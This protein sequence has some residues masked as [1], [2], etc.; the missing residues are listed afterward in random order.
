MLSAPRRELHGPSDPLTA[1]LFVLF[2][3]VHMMMFYIMVVFIVLVIILLI[4]A[5]ATK[6]RFHRCEQMRAG[7][8]REGGDIQE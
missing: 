3:D 4:Q 8:G 2:E 6:A 5:R 7:W 1:E